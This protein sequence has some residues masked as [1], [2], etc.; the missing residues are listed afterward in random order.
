MQLG[1][2]NFRSLNRL[3]NDP[4][5][6]GFRSPNWRTGRP[7]Q[8][9][10]PGDT[11]RIEERVFGFGILLALQCGGAANSG[12]ASGCQIDDGVQ[13]EKQTTW[14]SAW[15]NPV[16]LGCMIGPCTRHASQ[17]I[18]QGPTRQIDGVLAP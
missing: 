13:N 4:S 1:I 16:L 9:K 12:F 17:C 5:F 10:Y 6:Y 11:G 15:R 2:G 8:R 14:P 3:T 7:F 18:P